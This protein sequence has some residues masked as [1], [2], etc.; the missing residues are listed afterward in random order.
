MLEAGITAKTFDEVYQAVAD[1]LLNEEKK[2]IFNGIKKQFLQEFETGAFSNDVKANAL[3]QFYTNTY[4]TLEARAQATVF[5]IF[6]SDLKREQMLSVRREIEGFDD[7][8]RVKA[9]EF[10]GQVASFAINAAAAPD[11]MQDVT[12]RFNRS[13][14][15]ITPGKKAVIGED[16]SLDCVD[17]E[18]E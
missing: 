18:N 2:N 16:G 1:T 6:G 10:N 15:E 3:A 12:N 4:Q 11:V 8:L 5:E 17:I 7:N 13:I 9:A 14:C